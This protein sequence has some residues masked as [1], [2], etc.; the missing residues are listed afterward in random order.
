MSGRVP[1]SAIADAAALGSLLQLRPSLAVLDVGLVTSEADETVR[2]DDVRSKLGFDGT[3]VKVGILSDSFGRINTPGCPADPS[4]GI[5][6][7]DNSYVAATYAD[8]TFP[9]TSRSW[10]TAFPVLALAT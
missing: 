4:Q 8:D 1:T 3:G 10:T 7:P 9:V 6:Q 5:R 2:S